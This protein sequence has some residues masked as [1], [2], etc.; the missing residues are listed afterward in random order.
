MH[1]S[2]QPGSVAEASP[3]L[4]WTDTEFAALVQSEQAR[5]PIAA[6]VKSI[7]TLRELGLREILLHDLDGYML[8]PAVEIACEPLRG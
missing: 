3:L 6:P 1:H 4:P 5:A 8:D 7:N 2:V